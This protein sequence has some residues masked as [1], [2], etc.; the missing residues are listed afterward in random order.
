[1]EM[2]ERLGQCVENS[3]KLSQK[4]REKDAKLKEQTGRLDE[5]VRLCE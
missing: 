2:K 5:Q 1:M 3:E 4:V